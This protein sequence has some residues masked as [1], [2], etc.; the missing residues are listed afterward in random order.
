MISRRKICLRGVESRLLAGNSLPPTN[1]TRR[2]FTYLNCWGFRSGNKS[3]K[4]RRLTQRVGFNKK[5]GNVMFKK[6]VVVAQFMPLF[7]SCS[8]FAENDLN[9]AKMPGDDAT[10]PKEVMTSP[11]IRK[12]YAGGTV[13]IADLDGFQFND[14]LAQNYYSSIG[15]HWTGSS[16]WLGLKEAQIH[17]GYRMLEFMNIELG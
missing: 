1:A 14:T 3:K 10:A 11:R 9:D 2:D 13:G 12:W 8:A 6:L 7:F 15:Y 16:S 4:E 5:W 17:V